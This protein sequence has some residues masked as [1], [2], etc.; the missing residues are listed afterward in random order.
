LVGFVQRKPLGALLKTPSLSVPV[1]E[2]NIANCQQQ[3][4]QQQQLNRNNKNAI[5][6]KMEEVLHRNK[7]KKTLVAKKKSRNVCHFI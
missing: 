5:K 6:Q 3:Q 2:R 1:V 4:H 7:N